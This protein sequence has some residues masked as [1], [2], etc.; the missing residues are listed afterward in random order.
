[1]A[2]LLHGIPHGIGATWGGHGGLARSST[3]VGVV[4]LQGN[5]GSLISG[6]LTVL[7]S[8]SNVPKSESKSENQ[9]AP[10]QIGPQSLLSG[11]FDFFSLPERIAITFCV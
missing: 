6:A 3:D 5:A 2:I 8:E 10:T 7:E 4:R 1:M 11:F 9:R